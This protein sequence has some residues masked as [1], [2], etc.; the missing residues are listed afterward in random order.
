MKCSV[1]KSIPDVGVS[2]DTFFS[3][4]KDGKKPFQGKLP[5]QTEIALNP[6]NRPFFR[7][8]NNNRAL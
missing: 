4:V 1:R 6:P 7:K 5:F 2:F 3:N 8:K